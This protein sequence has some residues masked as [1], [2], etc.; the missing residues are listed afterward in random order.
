VGG[1][2][3]EAEVYRLPFDFSQGGEHV[4]PQ[5]EGLSLRPFSEE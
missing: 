2:A 5:P 1:L 4:E 3:F